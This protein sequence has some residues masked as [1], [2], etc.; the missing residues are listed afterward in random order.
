MTVLLAADI[1]TTYVF[2]DYN[3]VSLYKYLPEKTPKENKK[4]LAESLLTSAI[5]KSVILLKEHAEKEKTANNTECEYIVSTDRGDLCM[6]FNQPCDKANCHIFP[7][8]E[9]KE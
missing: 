1:L 6:C 8:T 9:E 4:S 3:I 5:Q 7:S 2:S